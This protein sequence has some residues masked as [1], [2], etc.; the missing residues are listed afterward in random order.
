MKPEANVLV[1][2]TF[3]IDKF[4]VHFLTNIWAH[5]MVCLLAQK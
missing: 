1:Y 2:D 3:Y 4:C 5:Y